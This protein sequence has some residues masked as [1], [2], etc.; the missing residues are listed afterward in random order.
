MSG[1]PHRLNAGRRVE[2]TT[3]ATRP[4]TVEETMLAK[5]KEFRSEKSQKWDRADCVLKGAGQ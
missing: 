2:P 3:P 4:G 1:T 5:E